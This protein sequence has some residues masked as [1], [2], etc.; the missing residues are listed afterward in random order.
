MPVV[1]N[2]WEDITVALVHFNTPAATALCLSSMLPV[3]RAARPCGFRIVVVDNRSEVANFERLKAAV[4][5]LAAPEILLVRNCINAGFGLGCM[6]A[7]NFSAGRFIAFVNS[8]T[9]FDSDCF[10]PLIAWLEAHPDI[11]VIGP[12]HFSESGVAERS[13][14]FNETL[15]SRLGKRR[16]FDA[17][18]LPTAPIDVDYVFGAFMMFRREALAECGGFDPT[19]FL[20]YEEMDI[21]HRVRAAGWRVVFF[22]NAGFRH[23]GQASFDGQA[24]TKSESD[25]SLLYVMR[26]NRGYWAWRLLVLAKLLSYALRAPF[27]RRQRKL[28]RRLLA[29]GPPQALSWRV[30]QNCNFDYINR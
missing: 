8:D 26:K 17:A 9:Q 21:C 28:L 29:L 25:L 30:R 13:Y 18:T 10:S 27:R 24:D 1:A 5:A 15:A 3:L 7:L 4:E 16:K 22:P 19:I 14:G 20:F 6:T 11:G 23:I 2:P 12:Q